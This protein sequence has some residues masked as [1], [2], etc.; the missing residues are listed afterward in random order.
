MMQYYRGVGT[1]DLM[2]LVEEAE[3]RAE[4]TPDADEKKLWRA[5]VEMMQEEL[6]RRQNLQEKV[7]V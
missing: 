5:R 7:K 3:E 6:L 4:F 1:E 2:M